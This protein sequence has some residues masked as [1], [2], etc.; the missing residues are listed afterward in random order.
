MNLELKRFVI[1][2]IWSI[3][4]FVNLI[5]LS[6]RNKNN[7]QPEIFLTQRYEHESPGKRLT[8]SWYIPN[9]VDPFACVHAKRVMDY[10]KFNKLIRRPSHMEEFYLLIYY[11]DLLLLNYFF[12]L[13]QIK[14][15]YW[16]CVYFFIPNFSN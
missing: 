1:W 15:R 11:S 12:L 7:L 14:L 4:N 5:F 9:L 10:V 13:S 8:R 2:I 6:Y 16:S 3:T